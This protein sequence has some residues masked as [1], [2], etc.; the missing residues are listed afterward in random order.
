M[1]RQ[2]LTLDPAL[3]QWATPRQAEV[4]D[5][6]IKHG[7][8]LRAA[9]ALGI[10]Q[11]NVSA[12]VKAVKEKAA[13]QGYSPDHD[14][15][16]VVPDGFKVRGV[17]TYYDSEGK[18]RAQ[19]VKSAIDDAAKEAAFRD[20]IEQ[21]SEGIKGLSPHVPA[22]PA[23]TA[24][25]LAV[26]PIGDHHHGMKADAT[27][28][29]Q[30]DW[31]CNISQ[32]VLERAIDHLATGAPAADEALLINTGDF[33]DINDS[34]NAT[35][36]SGNVMDVDTR[37]GQVLHSGAMALV[38]A[39]LRLLEKHQRVTVWNVRGNHDPDAAM[40]LSIALSCYFHNEPRVTVD[41]GTSMFKYHRFGRNLI[42]GTHGDKAKAINLPLIMAA[43]RPG[44][45]GETAHRVW[46]VGHWHKRTVDDF[47]GVEVE[48]HRVLGPGNAWSAGAGYRS[49]RGMQVICYHRDRGEVE[50]HRFDPEMVA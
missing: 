49:K 43:D 24:D 30:A 45:W 12:T 35:P 42:G 25:L 33:L 19:W 4:I 34:K 14:Y 7:G 38:R 27:E 13:R 40:A 1:G 37:F 5:A 50:R 28:T 32:Q 46:H 22:P 47:P 6:V 39:V 8:A 10:T 20:F 23:A 2:A 17:S 18:P 48:A 9:K 31:D 29:G 16:H 21:L 26:Y 11:G 36:A 15:V 3:K 44:D 41:L